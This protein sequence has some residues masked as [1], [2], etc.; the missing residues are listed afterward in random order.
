MTFEGK[1]YK[2]TCSDTLKCYYGSTTKPV[3]YRLSE[4]I[5]HFRNGSVNN[6]SGLIIAGG[7]YHIQEIETVK[8]ADKSELRAR[9]RFYIEHDRNCINKNI[10]NRT[11]KDW[12]AL[13]PYYSISYY[14]R[15]K[16]RHQAYCREYYQRRKA[17]KA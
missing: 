5:C 8:Y 14:M 7:N 2:L 15:N 1:I 11:S 4:H 12:H 13:H 17:E 3:K 10:P 16:E 6:S 9:E